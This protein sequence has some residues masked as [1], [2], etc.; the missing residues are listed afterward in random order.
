MGVDNSLPTGVL[1]LFLGPH[2]LHVSSQAQRPHISP[3]LIYVLQA[4]LLAAD[5]SLVL[6][7][8]RVRSV[9]RPDR[10]LFFVIGHYLIGSGVVLV[11]VSYPASPVSPH[12]S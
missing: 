7:A 1:F 9:V 8:Q 3:D 11:D 10:I 12:D 2:F 6:P 5:G 4:V